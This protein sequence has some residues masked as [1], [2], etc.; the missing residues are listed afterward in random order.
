MSVPAYDGDLTGSE[1]Y[2]Q[3][4]DWGFSS[5][6]DALGEGT[7]VCFTAP[8]TGTFYVMF[9]VRNVWSFTY[10]GKPYFIDEVSAQIVL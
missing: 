8:K 4:D 3:G 6:V 5:P 2:A 7:G 10:F 1:N 9:N